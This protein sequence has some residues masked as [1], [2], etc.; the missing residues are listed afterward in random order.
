MW[1][2]I[3]NKHSD[4]I[5]DKVCKDYFKSAAREAYFKDENRLENPPIG[6]SFNAY[7]QTGQQRPNRPFVPR[8]EEIGEQELPPPK[9]EY[10][11]FDDPMA[12]GFREAQRN[13]QIVTGGGISNKPS[14]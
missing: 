5:N 9:K 12:T 4:V 7:N 14:A 13:N 11:D 8:R 10:I 1:K 3:K 6:H 2:H